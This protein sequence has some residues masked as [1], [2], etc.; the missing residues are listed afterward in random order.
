M[1]LG[2]FRNLT[3]PKPTPVVERE[4]CVAGRTLP[5]KIVESARA[6]RMTLRIDS[7]GQGL[8]ITVPPGAREDEVRGK[9]LADPAVLAH[10]AGKTVRKVIVVQDKL[11][12][13][14][15]S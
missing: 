13:V 12:S 5:L 14:V 11:V 2:F 9:A 1:T 8:R 6:R 10:V 15:V 4:Y 7:G 3:K